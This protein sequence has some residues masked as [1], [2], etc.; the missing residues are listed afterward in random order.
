MSKHFTK[1]SLFILIGA[2]L[3]SC[4]ITKR[5]P[6]HK[7]LLFKNEIIDGNKIIKED[8]VFNQLYQKS[9]SSILGYRLR[10][11]IYNLAKQHTDSLYKLK[12]TNDPDK[13]YRNV[14]LLSKKQVNRLGHSFWYEGIHNFLKEI[15]EAP[16]IL[17]TNSTKKSLRRLKAYYYNKGYFDVKTS[18]TS[19][20]SQIKKVSLKYKIEKGSGYIIDTIKT[21]IATPALDSLYKIKKGAS[22]I[23]TGKQYTTENIDNERNRITNDFRNNGAFF[24]QQNYIEYDLDTINTGKKV[25]ITLNINN[26][27]IRENDSSKTQSFKIYKINRVNIYTD[28]NNKNKVQIKDSIQYKGFNL[29]S[30]DKLKYRPKAITN[31]VFITPGSI[32]SDDKTALT[33]KYLIN[34]KVFNYP[35]IQ[36]DIDPKDENGLIANIYLLPR[37]K[38]TF[39]AS[40]DFTRSN[41]QDFGISGNTTVGIRNVFNGAETFEIG[42]RGT[43]GASRK[44]ANPNNTFFNISEFGVDAK[45]NFPRLLFPINTERLIKKYMIPYTTFSVGFAKQ[46]N[47]GLDKQNFTCALTY[48][49]T[50]KKNRTARFDLFNV[51][52]VKNV[53]IGNYF[54]IYQ[55]SY[56]NLSIIA[57]NPAYGFNDPIYY[58]LDGT[59]KIESG[60]NAFLNA[61]LGPNPTIFTS[62]TDLKNIRS[63]NERKIRLTE[64]NLIFASSYSY[65]RTT[66]R[67]IADEHYYAF[68]GKI[69]SAGNFL[70][71]LARASKQLKNQSGANTFFEVEYSQYIKGELEYIK[72]WDLHRKKVLAVRWFGGIAIPYGNSKSVP[73]SR[74]YFGGGTNDNR[75]WQPYSL[76]PGSSGGINDFNEAN[77]KLALNAELRFNIAG[78]WNGVLF[79]DIGNIWNVLDNVE[80]EK[81]KFQGLKSLTDVAVGTGFGIRYDFG[82]FVIRGELGF[83][84]YNPANAENEKWLK[85]FNFSQSV[86]NIGINYPF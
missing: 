13:Y 70:S 7:R 36:Y 77:M 24:F 61:V 43:I 44:V 8:D 71:L 66:K 32:F 20:T 38:Y 59:L 9:N 84:T 69:E 41:I 79:A 52:F 14:K 58:N 16:V 83:K 22:F 57:S 47:I 54:N 75:A 34:L 39:G 82:I 28:F 5:V 35:S 30:E 62:E 81:Y 80:D 51:Q 78:A 60:T 73:F 40:A 63:I 45:L 49:W 68:K 2:I 64:N 6:N 23:I 21:A 3:V 26:Q 10:L 85:D 86:I 27:I 65:S 11:N 67:D 18:Y 15:G 53:N 55:S 42:L 48:N 33:I 19:D 74:S 50:P 17:D 37:K 76:G 1:I 31:A 72:H 56:E 25:N 12:Y 29:Y 46:T 4:N